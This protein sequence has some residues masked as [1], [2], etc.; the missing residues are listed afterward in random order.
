MRAAKYI[1]LRYM[2]RMFFPDNGVRRLHRGNR[3]SPALARA[4]QHGGG[5]IRVARRELEKRIGSTD[6]WKAGVQWAIRPTPDHEEY[7]T[8]VGW[9]STVTFTTYPWK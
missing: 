1:V 2:S 6:L 3:R 5:C 9:T 7:Q 8:M 4:E